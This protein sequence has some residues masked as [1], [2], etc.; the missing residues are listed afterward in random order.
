MQNLLL[1]SNTKCW[2]CYHGLYL[3]III[4]W[5]DPCSRRGVSCCSLSLYITTRPLYALIKFPTFHV[6]KTTRIHPQIA[7]IF[8]PTYPLST[9][10]SKL[11]AHAH[12]HAAYNSQPRGKVYHRTTHKQLYQNHCYS[13]SF[14]Q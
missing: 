3:L 6:Y 14:A 5:S 8:S 10:P 7:N 11:N 12:L 4:L 2:L 9:D 1:R 13:C